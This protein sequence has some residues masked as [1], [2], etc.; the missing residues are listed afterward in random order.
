MTLPYP[1][2][3]QDISTLCEH[4]SIAP[5]TVDLWVKRGLLPPAKLRGGKRLWKWTEV[6]KYLEG[7]DEQAKT[8]DDQAE[9]I[10][11]ATRQALQ[12]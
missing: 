8:P 11:N 5:S 12:E 1:P 9:G 7:E 6:E 10:R 2:P 3:W 4:I